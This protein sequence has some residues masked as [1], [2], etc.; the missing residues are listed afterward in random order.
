MP[1]V[2][3]KFQLPEEEIEFRDAIDSSKYKNCLI[4][5]KESIRQKLKYQELTKCEAKVWEQVRSEFLKIL[6]DN[7]VKI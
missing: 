6:E 5:F 4:D 2:E 7:E 1:Q 3:I